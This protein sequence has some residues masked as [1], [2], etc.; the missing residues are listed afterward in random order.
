M[1][2]VWQADAKDWIQYS[3]RLLFLKLVGEVAKN[4]TWELLK[5]QIVPLIPAEHARKL[6][7]D[8]LSRGWGAVQAVAPMAA[9]RLFDAV[10]D[11]QSKT[12]LEAP[13]CAVA[14]VA[15][16]AELRLLEGLPTDPSAADVEAAAYVL[17]I[18]VPRSA[19]E[20]T[21]LKQRGGDFKLP[22]KLE[23]GML[24]I[25]LPAWV[26]GLMS[27]S[28]Y[29]RIV[30]DALK[31]FKTSRKLDN[32]IASVRLQVDAEG[33][34]TAVNPP[35]STLTVDMRRLIRWQVLQESWPTITGVD[36]KR[37][38]HVRQ[39]T[40]NTARQR[41]KEIALSIGLKMRPG[42]HGRPKK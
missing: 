39:T 1:A 13:W 6:G 25:D 19:A 24:G 18:P 30:A 41:C 35:R 7:I 22:T 3:E 11:W 21:V 23:V 33:M 9:S 29:R 36:R 10:Q 16:A 28:G 38:P 4:Q 40:S 37:G 15:T 34:R 8:L 31:E 26:P 5:T 17:R 12:N 42:Q 14:A 27:E 20:Q 32:Y 2:K